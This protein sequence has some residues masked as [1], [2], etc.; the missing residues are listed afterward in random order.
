MQENIGRSLVCTWRRWDG[1]SQPQM[2]LLDH[3]GHHCRISCAW[4]HYSLGRNR[5]AALARLPQSLVCPCLSC[6]ISSHFGMK[7]LTF[8]FFLSEQQLRQDLLSVCD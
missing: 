6:D 4:C 5:E 3:S 7:N 2:G 1:L 8:F